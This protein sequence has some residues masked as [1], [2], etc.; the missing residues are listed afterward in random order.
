MSGKHIEL[1]LVNGVTGEL[2]TA[3]IAGWTGHVLVAPRADLN[4]LLQREEVQRNGTYIL[5]GNDE[6]AIDGVRA[7]IGKTEDFKKRIYEHSRDSG[8]DF[9]D[10]VVIISAKDEVFN[11]GHWGYLES[12]LIDTATQA[13]RCSL[14]NTQKPQGRRLSEAQRSDM[15]A[16]FK[17]I[18]VILPVLGI[19]IL[20][21]R[22]FAQSQH[23]VQEETQSPVFFLRHQKT[24]IAH[25]Q[26]IDG[27]F[28]L[29]KGSQIAAQWRGKASVESTRRSYEAQ[30]LLRATLEQNGSIEIRGEYAL[31]TRDIPCTSP[32]QAGALVVGR[33]CNGRTEWH[34]DN[35]GIES[36]YAAWEQRGIR[37]N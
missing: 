3:E 18:K 11:E 20:R 9:F 14:E 17:Q 29:L 5:L 24:L 23:D 6:D 25:A 4:T 22:Q 10:R 27:E 33:S 19:H 34:W 7:Y 30:R 36:N 1:F 35:S 16:F 21:V 32:S 2:T 31:T 37:N 12:K 28:L 8:K 26:V 15:E 13:K